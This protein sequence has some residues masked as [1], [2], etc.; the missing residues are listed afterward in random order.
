MLAHSEHLE[1]VRDQVFAAR[2]SMLD[3]QRRKVAPEDR[4]TEVRELI[5]EARNLM[6]NC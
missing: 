4:L 5:F 2:D 3:R 1:K 6:L